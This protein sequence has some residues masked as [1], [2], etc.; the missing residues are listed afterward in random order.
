M[1]HKLDSDSRVKLHI[2]VALEQLQHVTAYT[3]LK[4]QADKITNASI[5]KPQTK[6]G[7]NKSN[8]YLKPESDENMLL[9]AY[10]L[11]RVHLKPQGTAEP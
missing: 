1:T 11:H 8:V 9:T 5:C 6:Q 3:R 7:E 10:Q 2:M 4:K